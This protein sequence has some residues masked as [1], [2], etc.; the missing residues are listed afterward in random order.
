[1]R[2]GGALAEHRHL[3][4]MVHGFVNLDLVSPTAKFEGDRIFRDFG[5]LLR[6][7]Q[8]S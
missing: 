7:Q 6:A 2:V 4:G 3:D 5:A 8:G 1:L